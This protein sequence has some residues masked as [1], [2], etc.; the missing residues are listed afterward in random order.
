MADARVNVSFAEPLRLV[1]I[2]ENQGGLLPGRRVAVKAVIKSDSS[3][4]FGILTTLGDKAVRTFYELAP[5][6]IGSDWALKGPQTILK[7]NRAERKTIYVVSDDRVPNTSS[8][9]AVMLLD[10]D[11][12]LDESSRSD[13]DA[14]V[15]ERVWRTFWIRPE[16]L[17]VHL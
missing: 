6:K 10:P 13:N 12:A 11:Q 7:F 5:D 1:Q 16:V 17:R 15:A 14:S 9:Q 3:A 8:F 4:E 2:T